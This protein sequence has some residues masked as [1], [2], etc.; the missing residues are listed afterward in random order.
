MSAKRILVNNHKEKTKLKNL[1][2]S[3]NRFWM[4]TLC[5]LRRVSSILRCNS[6]RF[7]AAS[8]SRCVA[9]TALIISALLFDFV[10]NFEVKL[11]KL[12]LLSDDP[13]SVSAETTVMSRL[14]FCSPSDSKL[15]FRYDSRR[16]TRSR[17]SELTRNQTYCLN[18]EM[19]IVEHARLI[20]LPNRQKRK[21][22]SF[23]QFAARC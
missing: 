23:C 6:S 11:P 7:L 14:S 9:L 2:R 21:K 4:L 1:K 20:T 12:D 8:G 3:G 19:E 18:H 16:P 5:N 22:I 10:K 15:L 13:S 17:L